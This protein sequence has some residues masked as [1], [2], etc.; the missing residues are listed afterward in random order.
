MPSE[1][2]RPDPDALLA[3]VQRE[4]ATAK[5]GQ[6]KIFLGAAAGVGKTYAMLLAAREQKADGV[7]VLVGVVETHGRK[8]TEALL[9]GLAV[10]P[11]SEIPYRGVALREF[12]LDAALACKPRLI[13]V[14]ELAHSN[15]PG[16]RHAKRW[17]DVDELLD[18]GIDVYTAMNVQH[19]E[20]LNDVVG[21][22]TGVRVWETVPD[23]VFDEADEVELVDLPPD[24]LLERL[25]EGKV[26]VPEAAENAVRNFFRKGNLLA[27]RELAL[28]RTADRVE[29]Q[30][31]VYRADHGIQ[32]SWPV[33]ER[34]VV[35]VG[36]GAHAD[37]VIRAGRRVA[38]R[39][40]ARWSAVYVETPK[41]Q[42]LPAEE[43]DRILRN[44]RLAEALGAESVTLGGN[45]PAAELATY[46][47]TQNASRIVV[48]RARRG[49]WRRIL[50]RSV[51]ERVLDAAEGI[52][53]HVVSA[54][55][56][57]E[58]AAP[59][60]ALIARSRE[61]LGVRAG[62][63][64][65]WP[66]YA[67]ALGIV[68]TCTLLA[69][70]MKPFF[71]LANLV[72]AYLLGVVIAAVRL[73]RG[74]SILAAVLGVLFFDFFFV[75]PYL[76]FSVSHTEYLVTFGVMLAVGLVIS[77]LTTGLRS[78]ARIAGYREQRIASLYAMSRELAATEDQE[79]M[80]YI[81]V[82]HVSRVFDSQVVLLFPDAQG[83]VRYPRGKSQA[84]ALHGADLAVAQWVLDHDERAGLGTDTL[85]AAEAHYLPLPGSQG[86]LG[87]MAILPAN[88]RRV[89]VPEQQRLL[90]TF[91]S[92]IAL[93][94]ER[95]QL[96]AE[97]RRGQIAAESE[98]VRNSLLAAISHDLRTP[99]ASIVGAASMIAERPEKV[100]ADARA[101]LARAIRDEAVRMTGLIDNVLQMARLEG[102]K[103]ELKREWQPVEEVVG[104]VLTR[105]AAPLGR[106]RVETHVPPDL[107][108]VHVDG[109]LVGQLLENLLL[110]AAKY[111]PA[112]TRIAVSA[113]RERDEV[114]VAVS[115]EGPGLPPGEEMRIFDKA[116]RVHGEGAQSGVGLGLAIC[117]AI[118]TL[119]GGAIAA[120]NLP[121][122]GA[123]FRFT[124]PAGARASATAAAEGVA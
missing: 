61:H 68:L 109:V 107:P 22:I 55:V 53:V 84:G 64:K 24:E 92:Q 34:I 114:W 46:A 77:N 97:A 51:S 124:L 118:V 30:M 17:Q 44:L 78:Q 33:A 41:L 111:A 45:D 81:A 76:S 5:R 20:S 57:E 122:G 108:M 48:G 103:L 71:E 90:D 7:D 38:A 87:V 32:A 56:D 72:M 110:N 15:A 75:P 89:F 28:R 37:R 99:L 82:Q 31:Q 101:D 65:R 1:I 96:A 73:G 86:V 119:H 83:R 113:G 9:E 43:R 47:H 36:P 63:K 79:R 74:P 67:S 100:P 29:A 16:S 11:R 2:D 115:D 70:A 6:L 112:G 52:D 102:G 23:R 116:Y 40:G 18:A 98:R 59:A 106:H 39:L 4:E 14:D 104:G 49:G 80:L 85:P 94:L 60:R 25:A 50:L 26:Y 3:R 66:A 42:R 27:L 19:I 95:V 121:V 91:A 88:P 58:T 123:V 120:E 35:G 10:L 12:D 54:E 8:E 105:L 69:A 21:Q 13:L 62:G 93:A 117:K